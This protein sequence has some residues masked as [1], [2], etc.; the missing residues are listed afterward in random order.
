MTRI[1]ADHPN[2]TIATDNFTIAADYRNRPWSKSEVEKYTQD[3]EE[4]EDPNQYFDQ[5]PD[6]NSF[7][8]GLEYLIEAGKSFVPVRLGFYTLPTI[9]RQEPSPGQ[10]DEEADQISYNAITAGLGIVMSTVIIDAS[11][12]YIFGSYTGDYENVSGTERAVDYSYSD[13]KITIG[14]TVHLGK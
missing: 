7:H 1:L 8:V 5:Y 13:S 10:E 11:Y 3:G 9:D 12:E 2:H 14:V 6:A 4:W